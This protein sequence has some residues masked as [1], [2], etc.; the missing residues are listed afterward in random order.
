MAGAVR[1]FLNRQ[2]A[3]EERIGVGV[4]ALRVVHAGQIA[5]DKGH[6]GMAGAQRLFID[7]Q[8]TLVEPLGVGVFALIEIYEG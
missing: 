4:L 8:R 7:R 1:L 3:L 6:I 2:R 5:E